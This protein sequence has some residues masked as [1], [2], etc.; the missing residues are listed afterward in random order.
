MRV[1]QVQSQLALQNT[2][3]NLGLFPSDYDTNFKK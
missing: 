3:Y 1:V 2:L